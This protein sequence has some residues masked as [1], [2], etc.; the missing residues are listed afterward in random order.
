LEEVR[1]SV[2]ALRAGSAEEKP[3]LERL[4][5]LIAEC[6]DAGLIVR[7]YREGEIP[8]LT[9][10]TELALYRTLQEGLTNV[11]KHARA[12]RVD[13]SLA[14]DEKSVRLE[15]RDNGV[16]LAA[17]A[18]GADKFGLLGLRERAELLHGS[19]VVGSNPGGGMKLEMKLPL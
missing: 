17:Q 5:G 1:R 11:R 9:P 2:A 15:I 7:F 13:V 14:H 3:F 12:S 6:R 4:E 16:G 8:S 19:L 10:Q 18:E